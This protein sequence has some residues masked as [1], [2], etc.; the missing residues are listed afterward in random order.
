MKSASL[1]VN[2]RYS[3]E[4]Y[5]GDPL[6]KDPPPNIIKVLG[7]VICSEEGTSGNQVFP[8]L[9]HNLNQLHSGLC[10]GLSQ[11]AQKWG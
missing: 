4:A 7:V 8:S 1:W 3:N 10:G 6:S 2:A 9:R 11:V 5:E